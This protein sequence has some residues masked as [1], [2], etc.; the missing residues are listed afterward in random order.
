MVGRNTF[1]RKFY[2]LNMILL[3]SGSKVRVLV[4]PTNDFNWV[5]VHVAG[6][7]LSGSRAFRWSSISLGLKN[8]LTN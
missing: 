2:T 4:H 7:T 8:R 5:W 6:L 3:I 1:M